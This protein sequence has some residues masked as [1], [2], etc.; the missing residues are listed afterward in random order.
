LTTNPPHVHH[1]DADAE[2]PKVVPSHWRSGGPITLAS[3][4]S[5]AP[6]LEFLQQNLLMITRWPS[7]IT[8]PRTSTNTSYTTPMDATLWAQ[9]APGDYVQTVED[10]AEDV[11]ELG[12]EERCDHFGGRP[13][14]FGGN[15][16]SVVGERTVPWTWPHAPVRT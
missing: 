11:A 15:W 6:H 5:R 13:F 8:T 4:T 2:T 10:A 1:H 14:L 3:D 9:W 16:W 12:V 7:H